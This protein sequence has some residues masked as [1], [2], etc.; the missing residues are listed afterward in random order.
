MTLNYY[1]GS[2]PRQVGTNA[3]DCCDPDFAAANTFCSDPQPATCYKGMRSRTRQCCL[4]SYWVQKIKN[5][6]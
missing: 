5:T 3:D 2:R 6:Y 1:G 4:P